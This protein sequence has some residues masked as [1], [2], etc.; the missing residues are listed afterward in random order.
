MC[1][2]RHRRIPVRQPQLLPHH[3][4]RP[5]AAC[6]QVARRLLQSGPV[7]SCGS[8]ILLSVDPT[9]CPDTYTTFPISISQILT[10]TS[11]KGEGRRPQLS[12]QP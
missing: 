8:A 4:Q 7:P 2:L 6:A 5:A 3:L 12:L 10:N 9:N 1:Q 11:G